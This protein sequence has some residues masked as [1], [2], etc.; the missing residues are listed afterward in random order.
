VI[1]RAIDD[2]LDAVLAVSPASMQVY[3]G[4]MRRLSEVPRFSPPGLGLGVGPASWP[5]ILSTENEADAHAR[6]RNIPVYIPVARGFGAVPPQPGGWPQVWTTEGELDLQSRLSRL[7][8]YTMPIQAV[9][10]APAMFGGVQED[11]QTII[12]KAPDLLSKLV[13]ILNTAGP[14]L[15]TVVLIAQD[16]ALGQIVSR[17]KTLQA[18]AAAKPSAAAAPGVAPTADTGISKLV[19]A[20]DAAIFIDKHPAAKFTIDHPILVGIG[21]V[22]ILGG[23]GFGIGRLS[24]RCRVASASVGRRYRRRR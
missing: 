22:A 2:R 24:K 8:F 18:S 17:L 14:H 5:R 20:L 11:L 6:V 9:R 4:V 16:P 19:P 21:V 13:K 12:Q 15:D 7:P 23:I 3:A 10:M 1:A